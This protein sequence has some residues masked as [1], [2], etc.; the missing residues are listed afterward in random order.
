MAQVQLLTILIAEAILSPNAA[1][2]VDSMDGIH[3][4]IAA[5]QLSI[6]TLHTLIAQQTRWH[7]WPQSENHKGEE[8]AHGQG[9]SPGLIKEWAGRR[10]A[11][12]AARFPRLRLI[13]TVP[14]RSVIIKP[15]EERNRA[16]DVNEGVDPIGPRHQ[17][18]VSQEEPLNRNLPEDPERLLDFDQL[19]CMF[20]GNIDSSFLEGDG[21]ERSA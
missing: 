2:A 20:S 17:E 7:T 8:V 14:C 4:A 11:Q 3:K 13:E 9:S 1:R 12:D 5:S 19:Q 18:L 6:R 10:A 16:G 15:H 21:C